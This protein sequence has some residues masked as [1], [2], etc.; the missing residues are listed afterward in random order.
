MPVFS[1]LSFIIAELLPYFVVFY[2]NY[3]NFRQIEKAELF[4]EQR[5]QRVLKRLAETIEGGQVPSFVYSD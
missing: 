5:K 3:C 4:I 1:I 2:L